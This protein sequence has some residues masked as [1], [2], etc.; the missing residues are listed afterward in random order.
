VRPRI[1]AGAKFTAVR[2][3][4]AVRRRDQ[5][6]A[7]FAEAFGDLDVFLTP[8]TQWTAR[9]LSGVDHTNPPVR[10]ARIGNLLDLCGISV[11]A[12]EDENG[13]PIGLQIAGPTNADARVLG[14][15]RSF[16]AC[17]RWHERRWIA[18]EQ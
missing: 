2:Y 10:Y 11:Q 18:H 8:A 15:A 17:T 3:V 13:L 9:P 7:E 5:L 12:G 4:E 14:V 1:L 16:Q 6:K